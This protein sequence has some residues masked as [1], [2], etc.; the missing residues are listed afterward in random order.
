M[1]PESIADGV[2]TEEAA[3]WHREITEAIESLETARKSLEP[4]V[5]QAA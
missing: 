2:S 4:Y 1:S 5:G 3:R